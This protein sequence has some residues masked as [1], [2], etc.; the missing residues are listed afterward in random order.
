MCSLLR[1][2]RTGISSFLT[3]LAILFNIGPMG[4]TADSRVAGTEELQNSPR[5]FLSDDPREAYVLS[6]RYYN[7][8]CKPS[9][10]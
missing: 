8:D 9:E 5:S 10:D 7:S 1:K 4:A 3:L 6:S 2:V